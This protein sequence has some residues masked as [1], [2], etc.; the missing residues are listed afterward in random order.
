VD[1]TCGCGTSSDCP[2]NATCISGRCLD[3]LATGQ[4]GFDIAVNADGV[5]WTNW[6][7]IA[8]GVLGVPLDGGAPRVIA[9]DQGGASA[10]AVDSSRAYWSDFSGNAVLTSTLDGGAPTTLATGLAV[11]SDDLLVDATRVFWLENEILS[12]PLAGGSPTVLVSSPGSSSASIQRFAID[13]R[14]VYWIQYENLPSSVTTVLSAPLAGGQPVTIAAVQEQGACIATD[15]TNVYWAT[16]ST[17]GVSIWKA[18]TASD[19]GA[20]TKLSSGGLPGSDCAE[21]VVDTSSVYWVEGYKATALGVDKVPVDGG[22]NVTLVSQQAGAY[23]IAV[24]DTS[25]YFLA[26][27]GGLCG[28]VEAGACTGEVVKLTPK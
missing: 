1:G 23:Q 2:G 10:L 9:T 6:S 20:A 22:P 17:Q 18:P 27:G 4:R 15:G 11:S 14:N 7:Y 24:D 3:V 19:A 12:M 8:T 21:M 28:T 13:Q 5:Y 16:S 26:N 25:L